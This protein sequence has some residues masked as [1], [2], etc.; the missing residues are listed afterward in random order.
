MF[1]GQQFL[2]V[3]VEF[4]YPFFRI[5]HLVRADPTRQHL[6]GLILEARTI[7]LSKNN[8]QTLD[9]CDSAPGR[10]SRGVLGALPIM[11]TGT[12]VTSG[13]VSQGLVDSTDPE[14]RLGD[15]GNHSADQRPGFSERIAG[16]AIP[17]LNSIMRVQSFRTFPPPTQ[18]RKETR[19]RP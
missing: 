6:R 10:W 17:A 4:C 2:N 14:P 16:V 7:K 12:L 11:M 5:S 13:A 15:A 1:Y 19:F 8:D 3:G 9:S 18:S